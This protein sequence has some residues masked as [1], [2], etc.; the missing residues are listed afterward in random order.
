MW[1]SWRGWIR[2][3][4]APFVGAEPALD[5]KPTLE[6]LTGAQ[7]RVLQ[8]EGGGGGQALRWTPDARPGLITS[9]AP[10][11]SCL[12]WVLLFGPTV[13]VREHVWGKYRQVEMSVCVC[14]CGGGE[15]VAAL[16][17]HRDESQTQKMGPG[18]D[19]WATRGDPSDSP[20]AIATRGGEPR[21]GSA[22]SQHA[23]ALGV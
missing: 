21:A 16:H 9:P 6:S 20:Q 2:Y 15:C 10:L 12:L 3:Q 4:R 18:T 7:L 11:N 23:K 22:L 17:Q 19:P 5:R 1:A 8:R 14:V 13:L